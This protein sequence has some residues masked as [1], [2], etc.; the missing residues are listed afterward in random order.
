M[1]F[2][3]NGVFADNTFRKA[4]YSTVSQQKVL[5]DLENQMVS[6]LNRGV[7]LL[8]GVNDADPSDTANTWEDGSLYYNNNPDDQVWNRYAQFLHQDSVSIDGKNY[9]FAFDDQDGYASDIGVGSFDSAR[10]VLES[11]SDSTPPP[12]PT[13]Q[14][15]RD[16]LASY[17]AGEGSESDQEFAGMLALSGESQP[18]ATPMSA[19]DQV[20]ASNA[21]DLDF[22]A[23]LDEAEDDEDEDDGVMPTMVLSARSF[24]ASRWAS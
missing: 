15:M 2:A 20:L 16:F 12:P 8:Q 11:W 14:S 18:S 9:G 3:C 13:E 17:L 5:A 23:Y 1:V 4:Q 6:A 10:I 22:S 21:G 19:L 7:G 24:T